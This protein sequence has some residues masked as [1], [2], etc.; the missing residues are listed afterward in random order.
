M[1]SFNSFWASLQIELKSPKKI[2]NWTRKNG[3][4]G[5]SFTAFVKDSNHITCTI[6]SG[7]DQNIP[8]KDFQI[9][10]DNWEDYMNER[11]AR[12]DLAH[13]SVGD[14]RFTKYTISIIHQ[15]L[16]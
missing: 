5:D 9:V 12:S 14:S 1:K 6:T 2:S 16:K 11:I 3:T 13:G 10:Y 4:I 15:F 7:N 8:K